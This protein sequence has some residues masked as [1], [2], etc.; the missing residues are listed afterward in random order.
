MKLVQTISTGYQP[1]PLQE[2]LHNSLL[3]FNVLV[4]HRRFG[5]TVF[6]LNEMIDRALRNDRKNPQYAYFAPFFGQAKRVAWD[7]LKEYTKNI[8]GATANEADLR[9]DIPRPGRG[10]RIRIMLLGA[11]NPAAIRGIYLDG[12]ILD[13]YAEMDPQVW[14]QVIRPALSD[15]I[16]WA[17]FIGT[18]KGR[19]HF[20]EIYEAAKSASG[21]FTAIFKASETGIVDAQELEAARLT[22]S[23]E[24]YDQE[25]ECSF[26]AAL[27]GA[28][29]GKLMAAARTEG[30]ICRVP[31]DPAL[32]VDTFWDLGIGD[33]TVIW[34]LQQFR[35]EFRLIDYI[36]ESG[37]GL[38]HY[39]RL[40]KERKYVYREHVLPHDGAARELGSG[41]TRQETLR[42][43]GI[44]AQIA[45]RQM[46]E[47]GIH[48]SRMLI[49]KC[50]FD[51]HRCK[52]GIEAL[53]NYE[54]KWDA[55]NK[56]YSAKPLHNWASHGADA[57]RTLALNC[58]QEA[59]RIDR[60]NLPR[61]AQNDYDIFK[62]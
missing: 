20:Y 13:E 27:V 51:E 18:P 25:F 44:I 3:R 34:F 42:N 60:K 6:S 2:Y 15:R 39:A 50:V 26:S 59:G 33:T 21:W 38:D 23:E 22:M 48:A 46:V 32:P 55:K 17:I 16:G 19:N 37:A 29:Y 14:S 24:E 62:H 12:A 53:E 5:K 57:F 36:E 52:R 4:C 28:Y 43:L 54:K 56:I 58:K 61:Q 30:R 1:R 8:P 47:D 9:V 7:Y 40:L 45:D 49:P 31:Y 35:T 10:D 41:N 11:D